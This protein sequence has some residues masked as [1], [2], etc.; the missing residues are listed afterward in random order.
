MASR[1]ITEA[2]L[3]A[4]LQ[5]LLEGK[6]ERVKMHGVLS[7]NKIN[8]EAG[9]SRSYVHKFG[10]FVERSKPKIIVYNENYDPSLVV[11][12]GDKE[13]LTEV[14]RLKAK[15]QKE[16]KLKEKYRQERDDAIASKK[17][18]EQLNSTLMFRVY[19]LQE[20]VRLNNVVS[21]SSK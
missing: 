15:L 1:E 9:L 4:A 10:A 18:V 19:E 21:I 8:N 6:P 13:D 3:E 12:E 17:H 14:E 7:L 16:K 2:S 20:D 5:R 11:L